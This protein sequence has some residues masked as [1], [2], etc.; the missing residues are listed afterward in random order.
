M[1][2]TRISAVEDHSDEENSCWAW[3]GDSRHWQEQAAM[4]MIESGSKFMPWSW[5]ELTCKTALCMNTEHMVTKAPQKLAYPRGVC[6]YCGATAWTKDHILPVTLT[7]EA[8]RRHVLVVP[9]CGECNSI[10]NDKYAPSITERREIAT[11]GLRKKYR[12]VL[13]AHHYTDE[14]VAEFGPGLRPTIIKARGERA[15]AQDR[16]N[17]P[18]DPTF[19]LRHLE[20]S[21]IEDPYL[22][23]MLKAA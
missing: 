18:E 8:I 4:V 21:G 23:G 16:I 12:K 10:I 14:E 6:V 15:Y 2:A 20:Q 9:S 7:G 1:N 5:I 13:N 22:F 11:R 17:F 19:D 3:K